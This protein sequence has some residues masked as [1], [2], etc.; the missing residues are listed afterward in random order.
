LILAGI[1]ALFSLNCMAVNLV[2]PLP[3]NTPTEAPTITPLPAQIP[4]PELLPP[5]SEGHSVPAWVTDFA[6]PILTALAGRAPDFK[7]D[8]SGYNLGWFYVIPGSPA[9]PYYARIQDEVLL[10]EVTD[11][12][13]GGNSMAYNPWLIRRNF[14][15]SLNIRFGKTETKDI[16]R[17]KFDQSADRSVELDLS[18]NENWAIDW[19][20][21]N[22]QQ[23]AAGT[24]D[25]F[26]PERIN[27]AV[28]MQGSE[29]A[30]YLNHDPLVYLK[31]CRP[32]P[33]ARSSPLAVSF[34]LLA[35]RG[36][37]AN[38]AI[39]NVKLWDLDEI[40]DIP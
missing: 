8:F 22:D 16:L 37:G 29:C 35:A 13:G 40:P 20:L 27:V 28:I 12:D 23:T 2:R 10:L 5:T 31:D 36:S 11:E 6:N 25:H 17:F 19:N 33:G 24:Y 32:G 34:H 7:D 38:V 30:V 3:V 9:G 39:D 4:T 26:P 21:H 18:R 15:L 1:L 14:V